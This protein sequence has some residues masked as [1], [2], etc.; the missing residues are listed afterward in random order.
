M[1]DDKQSRRKAETI[2]LARELFIRSV[3]LGGYDGNMAL[4]L[5][6]AEEKSQVSAV[7]TGTARSALLSAIAFYN[8]VD[9]LEVG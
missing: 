1:S 9:P 8:S 3:T 6:D 5:L 7:S 4:C 2:A